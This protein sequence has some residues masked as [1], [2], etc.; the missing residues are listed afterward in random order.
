ML[1]RPALLPL[2]LA[3]SALTLADGCELLGV[4]SGSPGVDFGDPYSV[5]REES[6]LGS[7]PSLDAAGLHVSV[8]H[9]AGCAPHDFRLRHRIRGDAAEVW[10]HHDDHGEMC[11]ALRFQRLTFPVPRAVLSATTVVLLTPDGDLIPL[12]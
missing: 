2:L 9:S 6:D 4:L 5:V 8:T 10:L 3:A 11:E 12:L 7:P 1:F